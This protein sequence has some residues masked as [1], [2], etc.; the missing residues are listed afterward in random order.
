[1]QGAMAAAALAV[2]P[3]YQLGTFPVASVSLASKAEPPFQSCQ[4]RWGLGA[5]YGGTQHT[6]CCSRLRGTNP[7]GCP[8]V[9]IGTPTPV[10]LGWAHTG[11]PPRE[12]QCIHRQERGEE[13]AGSGT[14]E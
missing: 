9:A 14:E 6:R 7:R 4:P 10:G 12:F 1:M 8:S 13:A 3:R 11:S 5:P 2:P